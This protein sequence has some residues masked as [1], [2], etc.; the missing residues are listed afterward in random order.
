MPT[1]GVQPAAGVAG[2]SARLACCAA[3]R[4]GRIGAAAPPS[5]QPGISRQL[6]G[7]GSSCDAG[8]APCST[9]P[10]LQVLPLA[11]HAPP[12]LEEVEGE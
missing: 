1:A 5:Q 7:G 3:G 9:M 2:R 4:C 8:G 6:G 10:P 12:R 11:A